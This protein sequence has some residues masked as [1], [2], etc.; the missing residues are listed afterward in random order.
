MELEGGDTKFS[1]VAAPHMPQSH[2]L[3]VHNYALGAGTVGESGYYVTFMED[4]K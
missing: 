1:V 2:R 4:F 3:L